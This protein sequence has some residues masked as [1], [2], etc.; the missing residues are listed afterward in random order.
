MLGWQSSQSIP[1]HKSLASGDNRQDKLVV[2]LCQPNLQGLLGVTSSKHNN[3]SVWQN[4]ILPSYSARPLRIASGKTISPHSV[5]DSPDASGLRKEVADLV[6]LAR[7][8]LKDDAN[9][10]SGKDTMQA[11]GIANPV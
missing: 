5:C 11:R 6:K 10:A 1:Y 2:N 8:V 3:T 7:C 9:P 4:E